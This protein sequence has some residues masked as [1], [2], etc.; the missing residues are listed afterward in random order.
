MQNK[1]SGAS[2]RVRKNSGARTSKRLTKQSRSSGVDFV[3][4]TD[5]EEEADELDLKKKDGGASKRF[6]IPSNDSEPSS[7]SDDSRDPEYIPDE[8]ITAHC[9]DLEVSSSAS[10]SSQRR[11][12]NSEHHGTNVSRSARVANI[13]TLQKGR[14]SKTLFYLNFAATF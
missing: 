1:A 2:K 3:I 12:K 11:S 7:D 8:S 6:S 13:H 14:G 4:N 9:I 10:D 5:V